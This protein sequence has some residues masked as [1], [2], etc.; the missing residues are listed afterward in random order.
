MFEN[1]EKRVLEFEYDIYYKQM[2]ESIKRISNEEEFIK[3]RRKFR[4]NLE[5]LLNVNK[6]LINID[7]LKRNFPNI[8][9]E[10][11]SAQ[12]LWMLNSIYIDEDCNIS[13]LDTVS[14]IFKKS[15]KVVRKGVNTYKTNGWMT[16][17]LYVYQV[18]NENISKNIIPNNLKRD[19]QKFTFVK[20]CFEELHKEYL[21]LDN[22]L[23]FI[24]KLT[25]LI[26]D[27]GVVESV[28][29]HGLH[30]QKFVEQI[31]KDIG[32]TDEFLR[33]NNININLEKLQILQKAILKD[34][35]I[36]T[37]VS[38]EFSDYFVDL[39]YKEF[40]EK[41]HIAGIDKGK[42]TSVLYM[43]TISDVIGVN[44]SIFDEQKLRLLK[45]AKEFFFEIIENKEHKREKEIVAVERVCD[46]VGNYDV[47]KIKLQSEEVMRKYNINIKNFWNRL[48]DI[49]QFWFFLAIMKDLA[50]NFE[51]VIRTLDSI[52]EV[53][54][55]RFG[56]ENIKTLS[57]TWVPNNHEKQAIKNMENE[58][59]FEAMNLFR[60]SNKDIIKFEKNKISAHENNKR[61]Y[62]EIEIL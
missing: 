49:G 53:T 27:I 33:K 25:A 55:S 1:I 29:D 26:H 14:E 41:V 59:F 23:K 22:T 7:E 28:K 38:S 4:K 13:Y 34:H 18:A 5:N 61:I 8:L 6:A 16:H 30:G 43:F 58:S 46:F 35:T 15:N 47:N 24:L 54:A 17:V 12:I 42:I 39:Q 2:S 21:E 11:N 52:F 44:E 51:Y 10:E 40:L 31:L 36:Y 48:Y 45:R 9:L 62:L 60:N 56:E 20:E 37:G 57:V 3:E 19:S 32:I 50:I